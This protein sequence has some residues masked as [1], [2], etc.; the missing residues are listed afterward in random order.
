MK[1]VGL[2]G[3]I[4]SGKTTVSN[5]FKD[6]GV[7]V[8]IADLEAKKLMNSSAVIKRKLIDLFGSMAYQNNEL[9][10]TYISSKIFNDKV[11]LKKLNAIVHPKVAKHFE[12]WLQKQTSKYVIKEAA[13]I[14]EHNMQSQYDVIIT[15]IANEEER[16]NRI[17]KRDNTSK[18]KI[19]S[20]MKHQLNDE[21]KVKMSDF[22]IVNDKLEHTK[23]QVL[24]THNSI[25]ENL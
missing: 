5:M 18:D 8:Y 3:G 25:L 14:F 24:K 12:Q 21:E 2:T 9:N 15:V 11:Y 7:P 4:G 22:V 16:I 19:V 17:L 10:R 1:V 13:I 6:L 23:E 20:I